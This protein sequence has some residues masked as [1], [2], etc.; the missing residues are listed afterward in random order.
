ML[1][2]SKSIN[3]LL[4]HLEGDS[5]LKAISQLAK[6][7]VKEYGGE[8]IRY[9][10][11]EFVILIPRPIE[12]AVHILE[13]F[14]Q[15]VYYIPITYE[16]ATQITVTLGACSYPAMAITPQEAIEAAD[17]ALIRGKVKGKNRVV[18]AEEED[19]EACR[20]NKL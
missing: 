1:F 3:D 8:V 12:E 15:A 6:G 19:I 14:R 11:D 13:E 4:G 9:G 16:L 20:A 17:N 18:L 5:V 10:G 7:C 2:R